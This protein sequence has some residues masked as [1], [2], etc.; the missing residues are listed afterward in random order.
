MRLQNKTA[1]I[2]GGADGVGKAVVK[3]F[4]QE[5]AVTY[6]LDIKE[7]EGVKL[8]NELRAGGGNV[9]FIKA[10]VS[11]GEDADRVVEQILKE[12]DGIDILVNNAAINYKFTIDELPEDKW[13]RIIAVNLKAVYNYCHRIIPIMAKRGGGSIINMGSVT[14]LV[15]VADFP[16]YVASKTGMLGLTRALA[17]DHAHQGIRVNIICPSNIRT[18]LMDWQFASSPDPQAEIKR[19]MDLHL[20]NRMSEPWEIAEFVVYLASDKATFITGA[21]FPFDGGYTTR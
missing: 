9:T 18:A 12:Q 14:S 10:D 16:A 21:S 6:F 8:Q 1:I 20:I 13:D 4:A 19:I 7:E 2:T 11:L 3:A 15:G 17:I 5:G